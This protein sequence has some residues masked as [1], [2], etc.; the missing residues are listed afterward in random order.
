MKRYLVGG[1]CG[2][3][4]RAQLLTRKWKEILVSHPLRKEDS[5]QCLVFNIVNNMYQLLFG[6]F[7]LVVPHL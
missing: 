2:P 1:D 6:A 4:I 5:L 3:E 7:F